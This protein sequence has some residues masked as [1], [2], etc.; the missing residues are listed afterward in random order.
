MS[1]RALLVCLHRSTAGQK[2]AKRNRASL[3]KVNSAAVLGKKEK[4]IK[5]LEQD[6]RRLM[7]RAEDR[8]PG[9][10]QFLK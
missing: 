1:P 4:T 7:N 10:G 8:L 6:G 9:F 3:T 2:S 5:P